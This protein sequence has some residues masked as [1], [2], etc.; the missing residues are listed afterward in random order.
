MFKQIFVLLS[1]HF[2]VISLPYVFTRGVIYYLYE[3]FNEYFITINQHQCVLR[4]L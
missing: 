3:S 2:L 1:I 4:L